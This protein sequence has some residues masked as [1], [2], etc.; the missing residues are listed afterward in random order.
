MCAR[1]RVCVCVCVDV[2]CRLCGVGVL[3]AL[4][5][6]QRQG[7][8]GTRKNEQRRRKEQHEKWQQK[9]T[10]KAE[11]ATR[12]T[13]AKTNKEGGSSNTKNGHWE[14]GRKEE[15]ATIEPRTTRKKAAG[16]E[17]EGGREDVKASINGWFKRSPPLPQNSDG[18]HPSAIHHGFSCIFPLFLRHRG[19][20]QFYEVIL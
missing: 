17:G 14:G 3:A 4:T 11:G 16:R 6:P 2:G 10:K 1:A 9:R 19:V 8:P 13:A 18:P 20:L 5:R 15:R 7:D 12:K